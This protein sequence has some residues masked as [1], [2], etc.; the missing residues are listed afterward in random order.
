[1]WVCCLYG[2][3]LVVIVH[4]QKH[5]KHHRLVIPG[6]ETG[7]WGCYE[8]PRGCRSRPRRKVAI[9]FQRKTEACEDFY[10]QMC[11]HSLSSVLCWYFLEDRRTQQTAG[12]GCPHA[13]CQP[14]GTLA[15]LYGMELKLIIIIVFIST[16]GFLFHDS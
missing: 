3:K 13:K 1:M 10:L 16:C 15:S 4:S 2:N 5:L 12:A 6:M 7:S 14:A 11:K 9:S 8:A